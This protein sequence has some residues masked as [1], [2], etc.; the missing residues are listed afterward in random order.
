MK[1]LSEYLTSEGWK[2]D[3]EQTKTDLNDLGIIV[4]RN[5]FG[6]NNNP[7]HIYKT[8][9]SRE[10]IEAN[11]NYMHALM[12][13]GGRL[14][15]IDAIKAGLLGPTSRRCLDYEKDYIDYKRKS[16]TYFYK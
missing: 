6:V 5:L 7:E 11:G 3:W 1:N 9:T 15:L 14:F 12:L 16:N 10:K 2:A 4:K 8:M 13:M